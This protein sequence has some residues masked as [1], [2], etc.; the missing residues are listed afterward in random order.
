M[1][2][3]AQ[4]KLQAGQQDVKARPVAV[5]PCAPEPDA[6]HRRCSRKSADASE[7]HVLRGVVWRLSRSMLDAQTQNGS[8]GATD[9]L[10][11]HSY[12]SGRGKGGPEHPASD[13]PAAGA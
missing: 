5:P 13:S 1:V 4:L 11:E 3:H 10:A 8:K 2:A 12:L 7:R 6:V 9:L